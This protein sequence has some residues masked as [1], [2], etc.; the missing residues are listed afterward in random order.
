MAFRG[1]FIGLVVAGVGM[2]A[3]TEAVA[4]ATVEIRRGYRFLPRFSVLNESGGIAGQDV[5]FRVRGTFDFVTRPDETDGTEAAFE[6]VNAWAS[7]LI[8]AYVLPL[9]QT[10][11]LSGLAGTPIHIGPHGLSLWKFDGAVIDGAVNGAG[12]LTRL[13]SRAGIWGD[14][15]IVDGLVRL[16]GFLVKFAS[17]PVRMLQTGLVQNYA[18]FVVLGAL[19]LLGYFI[20]R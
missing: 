17:Y 18:L 7:H 19:S 15:W 4:Q 20:F 14:T 9:D 12:W 10:L 1:L 6:F 13:S 5:D 16:T 11:N 3:A 8:L 2:Q